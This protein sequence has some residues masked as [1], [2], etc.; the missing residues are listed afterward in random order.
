MGSAVVVAALHRQHLQAPNA[1]AVAERWATPL[2]PVGYGGPA[3]RRT[4]PLQNRVTPTGEIVAMYGGDNFRESQFNLAVQGERQA[5][6]SFKPIVLA[7]A[8]K[9]GIAPSTTFPSAPVN[10]FIGD[11]YWPVRNYESEYVGSANLTTAT[12]ISDNSV[13]AQLTKFVGPQNVANM[14]R[15]LGVVRR[16][17][18]YFAIGLGADP[19]SPLEMARVFSTFADDGARIDG[20]AFGNHPRAVARVRD[21]RGKLVDYPT[22]R[23]RC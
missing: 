22:S 9:Q 1:N 2:R 23:A 15:R 4:T 21:P 19:V 14:A 16:L 17:N 5:G 11:R 6:S 7:T 10:I 13:Y 8:L 3:M 12:I 20:S 18:P